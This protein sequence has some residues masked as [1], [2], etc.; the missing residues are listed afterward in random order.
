MVALADSLRSIRLLDTADWRECATV[1]VPD[2]EESTSLCFAPDGDRL[3]VGTGDGTI[4][5]W[6]LRRIRARLQRIGLDWEP[7]AQPSRSDD[8]GKPMRVAVDFGAM[9]DPERE[10]LILAL[11]P[12][13]AQAYHRRGLASAH[14][15]RLG[16]ALDDFRRALAL[17]PD[18]AEALYHRGRVRARQGK[19]QEAIADWSRT[20]A[21]K[22]DHAEAYAARGEA[23]ES[24]GRWDEAAR[25]YL[26]VVELR[27][28]WPE[29]H[30]NGAWLLAT[31]PDPR[32]RDA[33]SALV[34]AR[35]A[36][37]LEPDEG[38]YWNTM[39]VARYQAGDCRGAIAALEQ[40][41]AL[42]GRTSYDE[43]FLAMARWRLG[44]RPEARR[45]YDQ[46]VQWME[47]NRPRNEELRRFRGE[48][49]ELL[50]IGDPTRGKEKGPG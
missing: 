26:K 16:E 13:D 28:D 19:S 1:S 3:A 35:R 29:Y 46:A 38:D 48:A 24:L 43:F 37:E 21:L 2:S 12:F 17:K 42:H 15:D 27:P 11:C 4:Q 36:V 33:G 44:E 5:L 8:A 20:I 10:S 45:L 31:H 41:I 40:A 6:D 30:N 50:G 7:P 23:A 9:P 22:P 49:A 34:L 32:R 25:D 18:H 47:K 39:G 14:R